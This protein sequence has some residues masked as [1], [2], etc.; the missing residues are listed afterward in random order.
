MPRSANTKLDILSVPW[1]VAGI[2]SVV[3]AASLAV[4]ASVT[5]VPIRVNGQGIFYSIG[6][7]SSFVTSDYGRVYLFLNDKSRNRQS[8]KS[9]NNLL[10]RIEEALSVNASVEQTI[11]T[12]EYMLQSLSLIET[13][14]E[15]VTASQDISKKYPIEVNPY[16]LVVYAE[17]S[18]K[19]SALKAAIGDRDALFL[20]YDEQQLKNALLKNDLAEQLNQ[21]MQIQKNIDLLADKKIM[22][23]MVSLN[24][25]EA[26]DQIKSE[27][28]SLDANLRAIKTELEKANSQIVTKFYDFVRSAFLFSNGSIYVQ[29]ASIPTMDYMTPGSLVISYSNQM[30]MNPSEIPV[31]FNAKDVSTLNKGDR[32]LISLPGY[33]KLTYGGINAV[34]LKKENLSIE[35]KQAQTYLGLSGFSEFLEFNFVSPTLVVVKPLKEKDGSFSW[36]GGSPGVIKP[37]IN[38]GDKVDLEVITRTI[39]PIEMIIPTFRNFLGLNPAP[40]KEAKPKSEQGM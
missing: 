11:I 21:R 14:Q 28:V 31:F 2:A 25:R 5:K 34:V 7:T 6:T 23:R 12:A 29:Q 37:N 32:G 30:Y 18:S 13:D 8:Y 1:R 4:W 3:F 39:T 17:S 10:P 35:S 22:S 26:I 15:L 38:I 16:Q 24:N 27:L 33:P 40:P 36:T 20:Q 19:K 9:L